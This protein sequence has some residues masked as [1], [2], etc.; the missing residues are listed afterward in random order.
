MPILFV[1]IYGLAY[2]HLEFIA[3]LTESESQQFPEQD[4]P[5]IKDK[6]FKEAQEIAKNTR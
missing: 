1:T 6:K 3:L 5:L 2:I 4:C